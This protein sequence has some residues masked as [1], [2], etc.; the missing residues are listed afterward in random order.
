M[1][2]YE[3]VREPRQ[4]WTRFLMLI[5]ASY[6]IDTCML[7]LFVL[8]GS[9]PARIALAYFSIGMASCALFSGL[10]GTARARRWRDGNLTLVQL[11]VA[12]SVQLLFI[13]LAPVIALYFIAIM[14][15][16]FSFGSLRLR[17]REGVWAWLVAGSLLIGVLVNLPQ[18]F[19]LPHDSLFVRVVDGLCILLTL[20]RS[21]LLALY[22]TRLRVLVGNRLVET[23]ASLERFEQR[24]QQ[25]A[26]SLHEGLGQELTGISLLLAALA[27]RLEREQHPGTI[28]VLCAADHLRAAIRTTR[29]L[30]DAVRPAL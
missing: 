30:A 27:N 12:V 11:L 17:F 24:D 3:T 28:D 29:S 7:G 4:L 26:T 14:F 1:I 8:A 20:G 25:I 21:T 23:R 15:V 18:A 16:I 2:E 13:R 22:S 6:A 9:I 10:V 5:A 19:V